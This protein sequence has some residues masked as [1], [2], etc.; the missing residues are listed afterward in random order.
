VGRQHIPWLTVGDLST[1]GIYLF[2]PRWQRP[3][4]R[5]L[6][7]CDRLVWHW[8]AGDR[9]VSISA[10]RKIVAKVRAKHER[11]MK[12]ERATYLDMIAGLT[13]TQT[14][15]LLIAMDLTELATDDQIRRAATVS[16]PALPTST[17]EV[18]IVGTGLLH[19]QRQRATTKPADAPPASVAALP[20]AGDR[21]GRPS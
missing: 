15:V 13:S 4:A 18:G 14:K 20:E 1:L 7:V 19:R 21:N 5:G 16:V 12:M 6:D 10:S 9:P 8:K 3:L 2:G 11:R 17:R